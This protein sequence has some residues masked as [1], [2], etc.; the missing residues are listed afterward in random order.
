MLTL[1]CPED[2]VL[3]LILIHISPLL[4]PPFS[5]FTRVWH[6]CGLINLY[7]NAY[8]LHLLYCYYIDDSIVFATSKIL[9]NLEVV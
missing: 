9:L 4:L 7:V 1:F 3:V 5:C 6:H 2:V 8:N